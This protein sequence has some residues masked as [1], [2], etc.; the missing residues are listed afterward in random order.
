MRIVT[1]QNVSHVRHKIG[2]CGHRVMYIIFAA[3]PGMAI[4]VEMPNFEIYSVYSE[5]VVFECS[6]NSPSARF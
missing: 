6:T 3:L 2:P 5:H 4:A 1:M